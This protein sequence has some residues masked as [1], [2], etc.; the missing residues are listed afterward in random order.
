MTSIFINSRLTFS[1]IAARIALI[2]QDWQL[3]FLNNQHQPV[4]G[5]LPKI[6]WLL[7]YQNSSELFEITT[8]QRQHTNL[9]KVKQQY[10]SYDSY[11]KILIHYCSTQVSSSDSF[12]KP[13]E[14]CIYQQGLMGFVG[15]D[16]SAHALNHDIKIANDRPSAFFGHYDLYLTPAIKDGAA[17]FLLHYTHPPI[18]LDDLINQIQHA[19]SQ[20]IQTSYNQPLHP[21]WTQQQ[22]NQA[23]CQSQNYLLAGDGYQINLTQVWHGNKTQPLA[24]SLP[25]LI[26]RSQ[27]DFGGFLQLHNFELLSVSPELFVRFYT[28]DAS[29]QHIITKPIKGTRPRGQD[30]QSDEQL[31][32]ELAN[33]Q[34][35]IAENLM[36]VDLLRNDLGK[37]ATV[38]G[39]RTPIRF[40]IES[41]YNVHH[42][43]STITAQL[44]NH[45]HPL[46][47]LFG[48]LPAGSITGAPKKRACEMINELEAKPRGAYCG[49]MGM[50]NFN[51]SG[52]FNVLIRTLQANESQVELWAGGGITVNSKMHD[53]YQECFDKVQS[54]IETLNQP[55]TQNAC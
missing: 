6:S 44:Q 48:S 42:M 46:T 22:Y 1:E 51:G 3:C 34:K 25:K 31:R 12:T 49:S 30:K 17:G 4:I 19:I 54:I 47:V 20:P 50:L 24:V 33:S 29:N 36:I 45:I 35:D 41:F 32:L 23:F 8:Y 40:A 9:K 2:H 13:S 16:A 11:Q 27:A 10:G 39:V 55:T 14:S 26:A 21:V 43:V 37:Y 7:T 38:G 52:Q 28:D 53:E 15:Y 5:I 18:N